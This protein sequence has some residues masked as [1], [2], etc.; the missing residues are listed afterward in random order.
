MLLGHAKMEYGRE[1][2]ICLDK[3]TVSI[4]Y[5]YMYIY[6]VVEISEI[7]HAFR[8]ESIARIATMG[9]LA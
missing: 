6:I 2:L 5:I 8:R 4:L 1:V 9:I 7:G 3:F